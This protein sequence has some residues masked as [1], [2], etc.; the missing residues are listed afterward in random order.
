MNKKYTWAILGPGRIA[1]KFTSDLHLLPNAVVHAIGSR[2]HER[3]AAFAA[4]FNAK[5]AYGSYEELVA[6]PEVDIVYVA[7]PHPG[8]Y[9]DT[10]LCFEHG[11]HVLCEKPVAMNLQQLE[12]MIL[13]AQKKKVFFM[14]ALWTRFIPSFIDC[15][16][17][18]HSGA[19]GDLRLIEADFCINPPYSPDSRLFNPTLGGGSLLDI[20][21][22]PVF[23]ALEAASPV[24]DIKASAMLDGNNIDRVCTILM[25]HEKSEQSIL[26]CSSSTSGRIEALLHGENG[27]VRL[28]KYWHTPTTLDLILDGKEPERFTFNNTG[29]GYRYEAAEVM[30]CLDAGLCESPEWSWKKSCTLIATLDRIRCLTGIQYPEEIERV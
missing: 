30:R 16:N 15:M 25:S 18:V 11:K 26:C 2:S 23:L 13:Y 10:M 8:H 21:I 5:K 20:G 9:R 14:E 29:F 19:I 6:D 22:Y 28:N 27:M 3:A 17:R 24:T 1:R 12:R 7:T 4:E